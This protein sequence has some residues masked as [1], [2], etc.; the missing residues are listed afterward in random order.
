[1]IWDMSQVYSN[2]GFLDQVT[3]DLGLPASSSGG[4]G[5]TTTTSSVAT[6]FT[7]VTTTATSTTSSAASISTAV[8]VNQ[9]NQCG[10][11]GWSG[12]TVCAPPYVCTYLSEWYS[13]CE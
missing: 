8:L 9:W 11:T 1:M 6:T 12:G 13:Q 3:S 5:G 2:S 10:G 7:T 4:G